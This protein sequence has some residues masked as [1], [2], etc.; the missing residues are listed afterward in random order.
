MRRVILLEILAKGLH[1]LYF[2]YLINLPVAHTMSSWWNV[3][4][5]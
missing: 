1:L 4:L 5:Q 3:N 2:E